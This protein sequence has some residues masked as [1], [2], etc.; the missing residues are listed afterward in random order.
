VLWISETL[1]AGAT[2][3]MTVGSHFRVNDAVGV[4]GG[5]EWKVAVQMKRA[6]YG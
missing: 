5:D 2:E 4:R 1:K 3:K 6:G